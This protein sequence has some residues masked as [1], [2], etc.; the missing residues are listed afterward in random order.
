VSR[1]R[2]TLIVRAYCHL[3]DDMREQLVRLLAL[4]S[5]D[6]VSIAEVDVDSDPALEAR[7]GDKVPVLLLGD[8]ALCHY[9]LDRDAVRQALAGSG[10]TGSP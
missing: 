1:A 6:S 4:E 10:A 2:L 9:S 3:C 5:E 8:H 7:W